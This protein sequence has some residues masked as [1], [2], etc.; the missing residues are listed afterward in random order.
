M[1]HPNFAS[2][3]I[4]EG[5]AR[6]ISSAHGGCS[7]AR[8]ALQ[9]GWRRAVSAA[10]MGEIEGTDNKRLY[11]SEM[12]RG[13]KNDLSRRAR[14]AGRSRLILQQEN[15]RSRCAGRRTSSCAP[16]LVPLRL[17]PAAECASL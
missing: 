17:R 13:E 1:T 8:R 9:A 14:A 2:S 7:A 15:L 3:G 4:L 12:V 5:A 16:A 10:L 6:D 11:E